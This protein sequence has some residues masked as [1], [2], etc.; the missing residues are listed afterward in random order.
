[1]GKLSDSKIK[2]LKPKEKPY[3][4]SDG[5]GLI[6][7]VKPTGRKI[8]RIKPSEIFTK[9][10]Y[11]LIFCHLKKLFSTSKINIIRNWRL[12]NIFAFYMLFFSF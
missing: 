2:S 3:K 6:I 12:F 4:V 5:E 7:E 9:H 10:S 8:F 11:Y 1:M